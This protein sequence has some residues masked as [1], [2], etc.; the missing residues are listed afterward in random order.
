MRHH[1]SSRCWMGTTFAY[2]HMDRQGQER[3]LQWRGLSTI[4]VS[5]IGPLSN[6]SQLPEKGVMLSLTTFLSVS[7]KSIMSK[8]E[9]S[10]PHHQHQRSK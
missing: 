6:C 4:G 10:W 1:W 3:H 8:L 2:L 5:I 7:L 9:I